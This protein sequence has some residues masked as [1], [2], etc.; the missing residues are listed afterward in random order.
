[1]ERKNWRWAG[2]KL[3][4][5]RKLGGGGGGQIRRRVAVNADGHLGDACARAKWPNEEEEEE[6]E[7][8]V[9]EVI[10]CDYSLS[11]TVFVMSRRSSAA[12]REIS[13]PSLR[14]CSEDEI[15]SRNRRN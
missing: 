4:G 10:Y 11:A 6:E 12:S 15:V 2:E 14:V 1:M 8:R 5:G 3:T 9:H 7:E 13:R